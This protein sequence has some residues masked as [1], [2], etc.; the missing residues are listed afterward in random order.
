MKCHRRFLF[1]RRVNR[2]LLFSQEGNHFCP[3]SSRRGLT[4]APS[5]VSASTKS[6]NGTFPHARIA[7]QNKFAISE[8]EERGEKPGGSSGIAD[9]EFG[10]FAE[11]F[12]RPNQ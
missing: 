11:E 8:C 3:S 2:T 6:P 1:C 12:F 7:I 9:K 10:L 5:C 4:F